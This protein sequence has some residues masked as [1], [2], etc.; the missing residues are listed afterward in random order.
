[1]VLNWRWNSSS[2]ADSRGPKEYTPALFTS[3][4]S[5]PNALMVS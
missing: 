3:T 1:L 2:V 4:S 5:F